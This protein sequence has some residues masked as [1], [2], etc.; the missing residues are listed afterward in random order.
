MFI[1]LHFQSKM[2]CYIK[3][4]PHRNNQEDDRYSTWSWMC[5]NFSVF[6][7]QV[8][9]VLTIYAI[10][11]LPVSLFIQPVRIQYGFVE[12]TLDCPYRSM[13]VSHFSDN[14]LV[15]PTVPGQHLIDSVDFCPIH[16][17]RVIHPISAHSI[18]QIS[19]PNPSLFKWT[20][21]HAWYGT[22]MGRIGNRSLLPHEFWCIS[23]LLKLYVA[24]RLS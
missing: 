18:E 6:S 7:E 8:E 22:V 1:S 20:D 15:L 17:K 23:H 5:I 14:M 11:V 3:V 21:R 13:G 10:T 9:H 4:F 16:E 24:I 12:Q 19:R 2:Q